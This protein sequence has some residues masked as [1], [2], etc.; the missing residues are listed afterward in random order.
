MFAE[1]LNN[2]CLQLGGEVFAGCLNNVCL[3]LGGE[4]FA[5][6]L[7]IMFTTRRRGVC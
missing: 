7:Y 3:Q 5:E 4:V 2:V 6:C 1:C